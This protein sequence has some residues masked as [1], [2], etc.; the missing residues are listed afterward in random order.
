MRTLASLPLGMCILLV[1][2]VASVGTKEAFC[3]LDGSLGY[4]VEDPVM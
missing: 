4:I 3:L 2:L 1:V